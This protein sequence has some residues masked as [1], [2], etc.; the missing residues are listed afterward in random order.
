MIDIPD[1]LT[2]TVAEALRC[3]ATWF[4]DGTGHDPDSIGALNAT[5]NQLDELADR[6]GDAVVPNGSDA[7]LAPGQLRVLAAVAQAA[8]KDVAPYTTNSG[9]PAWYAQRVG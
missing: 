3:R 5:A 9:I 4:R 8:V 6:I 1:D 7:L 2:K